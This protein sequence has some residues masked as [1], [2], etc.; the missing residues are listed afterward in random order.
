[1][2]SV[3]RKFAEKVRMPLIFNELI[4]Q[5]PCPPLP[6][7]RMRKLIFPDI[8]FPDKKNRGATGSVSCCWKAAPSSILGTG[9]PK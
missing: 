8:P 4:R 3:N 1:M 5:A 9:T 7:F 6:P 2:S